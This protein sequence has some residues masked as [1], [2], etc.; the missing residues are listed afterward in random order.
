[1]TGFFLGWILWLSGLQLA[2]AS[3]LTPIKGGAMTLFAFV[4]SIVML[5]ERPSSRAFLGAALATAGVVLVSL[6]T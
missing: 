1:V 3:V 5:R 2:E 4:I 6:G